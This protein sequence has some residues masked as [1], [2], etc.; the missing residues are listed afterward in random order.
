MISGQVF[1]RRRQRGFSLVESLVALLVL[2]LGLL[3]VGMMQLT[4]LQGAHMGYQR[5]LA[6]LIATDAQERAWAAF[7][8]AVA[9]DAGCSDTIA[10]KVEGAMNAAWP[11]DGTG[12]DGRETLPGLEV[13][14]TKAG[15]SFTVRVAWAENRYAPEEQGATAFDYLFGLPGSAP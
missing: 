4:S 2:A 15:C 11:V 5:S 8:A 10:G 13:T 3:A 1:P 12:Y 6:T 7:G 14:L 9:E